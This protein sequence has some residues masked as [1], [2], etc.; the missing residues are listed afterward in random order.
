MRIEYN[1]RYY[2]TENE[3]KQYHIQLKGFIKKY[4]ATKLADVGEVIHFAQAQQRQG[5]YV[6]LYLSYEAA[7][8]F[9]HVMCTHSLAKDDIYAVAYSFEKAESINSTYEHQTSYVS[10]HHF[11]FVESSEV[12][13]TNI[14]RVQQ[15]IVEGE[16]YQVNYTA[17]LTDNIYYPI[18]T[19]YERLTQF[20]NGNYTALLQTDEIQVSSISPELF[21]QKGQFNNVDNVII[22]KPMK[23]TMPRGK[24]EA[25]DQQYYKTLQTSSKDRAENVM[26]VDLL[27]NDIGRISQSGSIK[28]YKLFFIEAYKT[29]F[30]MTS[31]VSG[32]LKTN[33][34]LTQILT[35]LFPCGS[36]TGAPKLNTM[37]Y[38]KQFE[39][40]PR[41]IY[42][43]AIGL[44][45]PTEDDKM[46]FN[47]P[48]RTIE[49]KYGQAIYGVGAG[50]TIDSKPKDEVNEF[51]AKTK[52][53]EML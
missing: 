15:A 42:C 50:I 45:L 47:I 12:M 32:T 21:F 36:I 26:I 23:G 8:Y 5:R 46:I 25:E 7:K 51:Y 24:T 29:V 16:T 18:S 4:V 14:K 53:L 28:V 10:K 37:K 35:S 6:S 11:S 30:Q 3:Y 17:R 48:I 22:S 44:L 34:D 20:S 1:Y 40:S 31:M 9:N 27:R 38:I 19:L 13:M 39:S 2:L 52:I 41:G 33:T 49:Y 43:G